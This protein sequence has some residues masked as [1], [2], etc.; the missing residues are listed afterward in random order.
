MKRFI[1]IPIGFLALALIASIGALAY[2]SSL[3][4]RA[5]PLVRESKPNGSAGT[6]VPEKRP[7]PVAPESG[8]SRPT[9]PQ[10][11]S[12]IAVGDIML[13]RNVAAKIKKFKDFN[14]P[15]ASTSALL[16][17]ADAVFG[18][19]ESP[20][21][22]GPVVPTGSFTFHAD[23]GAEIALAA[24]NFR[25]LSLANNHMP[26]YGLKGIADTIKY[27]D[28]VGIA[29]TGA[30]NDLTAASLPAF[31][32]IK[33]IKFAIL[34]Y[35][36]SD[37][38]PPGYGASEKRAGTALMDV[39][40]MKE[41]VSRAKQQA[42]LVVVS[43]HSGKEYTEELTNS[44]MTFA[45]AAVD[46]G[47][48]LVLG[49]HPHVTQRAEKYKDK[50]IFYS[51]GNFIFDQMWSEETR[52]GVAVRFYFKAGGLTK[53]EVCPIVI[54]DYARPVL[55]EQKTAEEIFGRLRIEPTDGAVILAPAD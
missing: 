50:Y 27:L 26:N 53:A 19:L 5:V 17:G 9:E 51:L 34:A 28:E 29:H 6:I 13:S 30:G 7:S 23:P 39:A 2:Q 46:A 48:E 42:D 8:L 4:A 43:M 47:A 54:F 12:L 25:I 15:F 38:V 14:Y 21:T 55:A 16:R 45:H 52:R 24:A 22:P 40:K 37:V 31:L 20:I 49:H 3:T 10:E 36:D 32:E 33:G 1:A 44:Q 41:A 18:N 35:N 11:V